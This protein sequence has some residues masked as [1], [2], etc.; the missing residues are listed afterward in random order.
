MSRLSIKG[1]LYVIIALLIMVS[2]LIGATAYYSMSHIRESTYEIYETAERLSAMDRARSKM[3]AIATN[4]REVVLAGDEKEMLEI[5]A[6]IDE[7]AAS[8]DEDMRSIGATTRLKDEWRALEEVWARHKAVAAEIIELSRQNTNGKALAILEEECNPLRQKEAEMFRT[9]LRNQEGIED[10]SALMLSIPTDIRE[11]VLTT[12]VE[13]M[14]G[15]KKLIEKEVSELEARMAAAGARITLRAEWKALEDTWKRHKEVAGRII[16][17]SMRNS[18][19]RAKALITSECN[20]LRLA[21]DRMFEALIA[22]QEMF[23]DAA[24]E[25]ANKSFNQS[26]AVLLSVAG[27]GVLLGLFLSWLTVSRLSRALTSVIEALNGSSSHVEKIAAQI[28]GTSNSLAEGSSDQAASLVETSAALDKVASMTRQNAENAMKTSEYTK[29]TVTRIDDGGNIVGTVTEAMSE[30]SDSAEKISQIIKTI[31]GISFQTNLLALN[32]AVEAARAGEAGKG[33]AV[34]ADEVRNLAQR[35]AKAAKDTSELIEG[36][37]QRV[38]VGSH[39]VNQLSASF[40]E[41]E[42]GA[43]EVGRLILDIT[44]ATTEQAGGV[45]QVNTAVAR[46]ESVTQ[47]N[48]ATAEESASASR[49]LS[50]QTVKMNGIVHDLVLLVNGRD[51]R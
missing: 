32:A 2:M 28:A 29:D 25:E 19:G 31:E 4:V 51:G 38:R 9:V 42:E 46:M 47:E 39:N 13:K 41:I 37:V 34:V 18:N 48:A 30:I 1:Q 10:I 16:D 15:I 45:E 7:V 14:A 21:E 24:T 26:L 40:K 3:Q 44:D 5:K 6:L 20:P 35:S 33:F 11:I 23:F 8:L 17:L 49:K 36:S 22:K 12:D 43:R 50:E 27:L